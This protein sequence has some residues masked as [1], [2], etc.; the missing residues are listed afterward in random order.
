MSNGIILQSFF[1]LSMQCKRKAIDL[2]D[3]W[4]ITI[5]RLSVFYGYR[6]NNAIGLEVWNVSYLLCSTNQ[7]RT[8]S[9]ENNGII[10]TWADNRVAIDQSKHTLTHAGWI[11]IRYK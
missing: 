8:K 9:D 1:H 10:T 6:T 3:N 7:R 5:N 4:S 11:T 2:N